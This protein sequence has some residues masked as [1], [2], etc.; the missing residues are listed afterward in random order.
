MPLCFAFLRAINVG[1]RH[2]KMDRLRRIFT[3]LDCDAVQTHIASGN[4]IFRTKKRNLDS[5]T[6]TIE[7]AL[8]QELGFDVPV[9]LR[10]ADEL[11]Q[12][13]EHKPFPVNQMA[14][15]AAFN[16]AFMAKRDDAADRVA[17]GGLVT[18][19]DAFSVHGGEVY[20]LCQ[21]KQSESKFSN[22][23]LERALGRP[24][25]IRTLKTI[26]AMAEKH[27]DWNGSAP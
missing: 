14:R 27:A 21:R 24:A 9:F 26:R 6:A 5:L 16:V 17:V 3:D 20:W 22:V 1:G 15:A 8:A 10:T 7:K 11:I 25:T 4:V 13:A 2:V 19:I 18:D 23:Q 12:V